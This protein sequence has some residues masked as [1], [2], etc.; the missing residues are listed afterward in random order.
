MGTLRASIVCLA[1]V[2]AVGAAP[3]RSAFAQS[4]TTG[5][6]GGQ[7]IDSTGGAISGASITIIYVQTG[8]RRTVQ[9]DREDRFSF[10]HLQPGAYRLES[11]APGFEPLQQAVT[12]PLGRTETVTLTLPIA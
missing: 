11:V 6:V 3:A 7:V 9:S 8:F 1:L 4:E 10:P 5:A 12:V 2:A